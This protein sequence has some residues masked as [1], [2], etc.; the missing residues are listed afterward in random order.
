[1]RLYID[2]GR[3]GEFV[4]ELISSENKRR[5]DEAQK[6]EE[7]KMWELYLHSF[8]DKSFTDWRAEVTKPHQNKPYGK[9]DAEMT[10]EDVDNIIKH[11]FKNAQS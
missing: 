3:F 6:E 2:S 9:K 7:Q 1:M 10:N 8:S 11:L 5:Q 4:F